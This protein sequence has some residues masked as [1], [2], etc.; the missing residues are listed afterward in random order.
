MDAC[1]PARCRLPF[2]LNIGGSDGNITA[3]T[4]LLV[5]EETEET[6]GH[7]DAERKSVGSGRRQAAVDGKSASLIGAVKRHKIAAAVASVVLVAVVI[8]GVNLP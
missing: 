3:R 7:G 1:A 2:L 8:T 5:I 4:E 6:N